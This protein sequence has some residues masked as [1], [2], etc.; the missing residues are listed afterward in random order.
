MR[1]SIIAAVAAISLGCSAQPAPAQTADEIKQDFEL[2]ERIGS[3]KAYE[4]FL[5][6][7]KTGPYADIVRE[8]LKKLYE[9]DGKA[10]V[11]FNG[12]LIEQ[13]RK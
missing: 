12:R 10:D 1:K 8:R 9:L 2:V 11:M 4:V 5:S 7:H 3:R 13:Q 6:Q